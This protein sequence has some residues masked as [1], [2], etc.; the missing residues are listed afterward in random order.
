MRAPDKAR[1]CEAG[2]DSDAMYIA[3]TADSPM[4]AMVPSTV[5]SRKPIDLVIGSPVTMLS[6]LSTQALPI[7]SPGGTVTLARNG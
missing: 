5:L 6:A 7:G 1:R 2:N 4:M 3:A